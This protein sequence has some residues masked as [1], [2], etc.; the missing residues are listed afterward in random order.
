MMIE[1]RNGLV[2]LTADD[3]M[4]LTNEET[5]SKKVFLGKLDA[6]ENWREVE[7]GYELPETGEMTET[8]QKAAAYDI[9][10][11]VVSE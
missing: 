1:E 3:G 4:M 2:I 6:V 7:E 5:A 11:G 10:V 8:E 9:L